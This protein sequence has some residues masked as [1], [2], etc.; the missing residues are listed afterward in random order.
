MIE[1]LLMD[2]VD[3]NRAPITPLSHICEMGFVT[4]G[5]TFLIELGLDKHASRPFFNTEFNLKDTCQMT[6]QL[7]KRT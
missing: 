7:H 6:H 4:F 3:N 1:Q 2:V 5:V